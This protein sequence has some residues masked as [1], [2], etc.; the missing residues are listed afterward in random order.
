LPAVGGVLDDAVGEDEVEVV[1]WERQAL[2]VAT[3]SR[4]DRP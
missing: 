1:V 4:A 2:A 3:S